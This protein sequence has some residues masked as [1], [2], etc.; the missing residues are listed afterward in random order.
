MW[1][2]YDV[3][4]FLLLPTVLDLCL[5]FRKLFM[6]EIE[7][8]ETAE[9]SGWLHVRPCRVRG[10]AHAGSTVSGQPVQRCRPARAVRV[11]RLERLVLVRAVHNVNQ[12]RGLGQRGVWGLVLGPSMGLVWVGSGTSHGN[13]HGT[14]HGTAHGASRGTSHGN[15]HGNSHGTSYARRMERP[16]RR[17][18][19]IPT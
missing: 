6:V 12:F 19:G 5:L 8:L 11:G 14:S 2:N 1:K 7:A 17:P 13:S 18:L 15:Y 3:Q 16:M 9:C 4:P 10:R